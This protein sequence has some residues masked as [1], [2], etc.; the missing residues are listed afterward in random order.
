MKLKPG[1]TV[2][3]ELNDEEQQFRIVHSDGDGQ[4]YLSLEA[5]LAK[6]L[7]GMAVGDTLKW[8]V[9]VPG[10]ALLRVKLVKVEERE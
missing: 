1:M 2:T 8:R 9:D 3:V 10:G 4:E 5:P 7:G 6:I